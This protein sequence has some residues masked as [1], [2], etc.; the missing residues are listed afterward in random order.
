MRNRSPATLRRLPLRARL[1]R[2]GR[3]EQ[4]LG[5]RS[6][7][8]RRHCTPRRTS[9]RTRRS[10]APPPSRTSGSGRARSAPRT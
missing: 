4:E 7:A 10:R 9:S 3:R 8:P 2:H 5:G 6:S 1:G